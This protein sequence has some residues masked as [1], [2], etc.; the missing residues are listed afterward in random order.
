MVP[1]GAAIIFLELSAW[2]QPSSEAEIEARASM[3]GAHRQ[4]AGGKED[5]RVITPGGPR[6]RDQ[7]HPVQVVRRNKDGTYSVVP[8]DA[9]TGPH[10]NDKHKRETN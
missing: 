10:S 4:L 8:K 2:I 5:E 9:P 3:Y 1:V 7:V 6:R